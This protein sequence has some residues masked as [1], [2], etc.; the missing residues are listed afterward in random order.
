[1]KKLLLSFSFLVLLSSASMAK[2]ET[3]TEEV[4]NAPNGCRIEMNTGKC[5]GCVTTTRTIVTKDPI[6]IIKRPTIKSK[7]SIVVSVDKSGLATARCRSGCPSS[8]AATMGYE[9][10]GKFWKEKKSHRG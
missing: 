4:C 3:I 7:T 6:S 8:R 10:E 9:F 2:T 5:I 1:M